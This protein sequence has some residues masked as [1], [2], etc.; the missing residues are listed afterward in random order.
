MG[1]S[2]GHRHP[3]SSYVMFSWMKNDWMQKNKIRKMMTAT[4]HSNFISTHNSKVNYLFQLFHLYD[5]RAFYFL[6]RCKSYRN[7][8]E[9][10]CV[11]YILRSSQN[12]LCSLAP[13]AHL[14]FAFFW[15]N[16][17]K[18]LTPSFRLFKLLSVSYNKWLFIFHL[19][20]CLKLSQKR[21]QPQRSVGENGQ[22][23]KKIRTKLLKW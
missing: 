17:N 12:R 4:C 13:G 16:K 9:T 23:L 3:S 15:K 10:F 5:L 2:W 8:T 7:A 1:I 19:Q 14:H 18:S 21:T 20:T 6:L 22:N 11:S